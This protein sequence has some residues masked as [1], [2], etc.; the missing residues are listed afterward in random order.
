MFHY[1]NWQIVDFS[2]NKILKNSNF[3][4]KISYSWTKTEWDFFLYPIIDQNHNTMYYLAF[5]SSDQLDLFHILIKISGIGPKIA[6]F[7]VTWFSIDDIKAAIENNDVN[8][9]KQIQWIG[10]KTAKKIIIELKDKIELSDLEQVEELEKIKKDI[11]KAVVWLWYSKTKVEA[12]LKD[13]K[14]NIT[15]K[16]SVIKDILKNL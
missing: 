16:Q 2:W 15:D 10:P 5:D 7:I 1:F 3:W 13:Y 6:N 4:L 14:W 8:F 12:F 11:I 9:F